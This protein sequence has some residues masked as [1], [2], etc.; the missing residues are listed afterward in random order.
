MSQIAL[1][2]KY[3]PGKFSEVVGQEH[4]VRVLEGAIKQGNVAHA[5]LFA[6]SRGTGKTSV[7]RILARAIGTS[8]ADLYEIDAASNRG[9]DEV[10]ALREAVL[11]LPFDSRQ[12]VYIIDEVHM[13]TKEAFNALLKMLEE[14]PDHVIFILATTELQ[15]LPETIVSRCQT[16]TFR[17]PNATELRQH[18]TVVAKKEGFTLE[19]AAAELI[20]LLGDGSFRDAVGTLQKAISVSVDKKI[21]LNEVESVTGAPGR[22]L[23]EELALALLDG[24][25]PRALDKVR[26]A[27]ANNYDFRILIKLLLR[28]LRLALLLKLA[29]ATGEKL[30]SGLSADET[31]FL[32]RLKDH[33]K[34]SRLPTIMRELLG[35]Y[36]EVTRSAVPELPLELS[37]VNLLEAV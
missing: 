34:A 22:Q 12:K 30:V 10:R 20:A 37:I 21:V 6:G 33:P 8:P 15:R 19:P 24:Q 14:P 1:Y 32:H 16:F 11:S 17:K 5:Y 3:R 9:I 2:R 25:L 4:V 36:D 28:P 31:K 35:T 26:E 18:L 27:A 13:L 23:I 29:P 7:A